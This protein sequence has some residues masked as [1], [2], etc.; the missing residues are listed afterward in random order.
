MTLSL[1]LTLALTLNLTLAHGQTQPNPQWQ[2][3][4]LTLNRTLNPNASPKCR[5]HSSLDG[6]LLGERGLRRLHALLASSMT[7]LGLGLGLALGG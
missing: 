5:H 3:L 2:T 6:A 7:R 1:I 4:A